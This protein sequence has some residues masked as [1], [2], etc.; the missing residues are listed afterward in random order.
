MEIILA[1]LLFLSP[2]DAGSWTEAI[3]SSL[4]T[5]AVNAELADPRERDFDLPT[6]HNRLA[7]LAD[8]PKL[9]E[10]RRFPERKLINELLALNRSY[11]NYLTARQEIDSI[12]AEEIREAI[13]ETDQLYNVWDNLRD[14]QCDY[15]Y[16]TVRR[17][18]WKLL[19]EMIGDEAFYS[20]RM[21]PH[22]PVWHFP[23]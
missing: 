3:Q 9:D 16:V 19:R 2:Q 22:V 4:L 5:L 13:C 11:R 15:Y 12:H 18:A 23:N 20:G 14:A 10:C 8:T 6:L 1:T 21:P 17:Q 7:D